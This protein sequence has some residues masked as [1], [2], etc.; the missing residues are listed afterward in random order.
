[1]PTLQENS[2][3]VS[4]IIPFLNEEDFL[5]EAIESVLSQKYTYWE[6]ILVDDGST[7]KSTAIAKEYAKDSGNNIYYTEHDKH[8]NKGLSASR[9]QGIRQSRGELIAFLDADDVW[10]PDK[11]LNQAAIFYKYPDVS[12][13]AEA[14]LYW[15]SWRIPDKKDIPVTIGAPQNR[16]YRPMELLHYLYPLKKGAAPCPSGLIVSKQAINRCGGFEESFAREYQLYEDQAF[17][18]KI[19]LKESVYISSSCHNWY[20]Q[21]AGSIV[22]KVKSDGHYDKVRMYFL[23]WMENYLNKERITNQ[24]VHKL[25]RAALLPYRKP[26]TFYITVYLPVKVKG[27]IKKGLKKLLPSCLL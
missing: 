11:L 1:M 21:R 3:L 8:S 10:L 12:M 22:Q 5:S 20:R 6:L 18:L 25:L 2:P 13:V 24:D 16:A 9:N 19:Y 26:N 27:V 7:D 15:F 14:S 17:L 4:V 23:E